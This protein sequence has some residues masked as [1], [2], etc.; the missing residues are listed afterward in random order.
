[1]PR[2]SVVIPFYNSNQWSVNGGEKRERYLLQAVR[3]AQAQVLGGYEDFEIIVV[4]DGSED[5]YKRILGRL[6]ENWGKKAEVYSIPHQGRSYARNYGFE[7]S[8]G[9][10]ILFLDSDDI[11]H[12]KYLYRTFD[13]L[14]FVP[15]AHYIYTDF[16]A[17]RPPY[18]RRC[19]CGGWNFENLKKRMCFG[20]PS[21]LRASSFAAVGKFN[22]RLDVAEDH[23]LFLKLTELGQPR[24][25]LNY[26][27]EPLWYYRRHTENTNW[28]THTPYLR[29]WRELVVENWQTRY[30]NVSWEKFHQR[31]KM[32]E[33]QCKDCV[34]S[35]CE[36][37]RKKRLICCLDCENKCEKFDCP[38]FDRGMN[39]ENGLDG[40]NKGQEK[41]Q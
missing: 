40:S 28:P 29:L 15:E 24:D 31:L 14:D 18:R 39:I 26:L 13:L 11:L 22:I 12:Y 25:S 8:T 5:N 19:Y 9:E 2:I 33:Q 10:Y 23:D 30:K 17:W 38:V 4:D 16:W 35:E 41:C 7:K 27:P 20:I 36:L 32:A 1:M 34:V 37:F 21:L 3:S 6:P